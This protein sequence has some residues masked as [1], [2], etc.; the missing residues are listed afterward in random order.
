MADGEH[1][2]VGVKKR[3]GKGDHLRVRPQVVRRVAARDEERVELVRTD[4]V[5][6]GLGLCRY[7]ALLAFE[8][9][10]RFQADNADLVTRLLERI[11]GLLELRIFVVNIQ[12]TGNPHADT[13]LSIFSDIGPSD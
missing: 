1:R 10:A 13:S 7:R 3:L 2:L 12:H 11:V 9:L 8:L 6:P 4:L 5:D